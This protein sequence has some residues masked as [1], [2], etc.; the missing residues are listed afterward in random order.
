MLVAR[1]IALLMCC[2]VLVCPALCIDV[3]QSHQVDCSDAGS[4]ETSVFCDC[5]SRT[6]SSDDSDAPCDPCSDG[7]GCFCGGALPPDAD[8]LEVSFT[9]FLKLTIPFESRFWN[10]SCDFVLPPFDVQPDDA[11]IFGRALLRAHC[12]LLI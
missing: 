3:G 7:C 6:N 4:A 5:C 2:Q 12:I 9:S 11:K 8:A 1:L 10:L